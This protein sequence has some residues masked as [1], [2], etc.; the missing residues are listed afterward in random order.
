[1]KMI[2]GIA[3]NGGETHTVQLELSISETL[4]TITKGNAHENRMT[5]RCIDEAM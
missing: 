5:R 4:A 2:M 1:M 3:T